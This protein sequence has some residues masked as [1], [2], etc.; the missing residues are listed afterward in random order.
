MNPII[1]NWKSLSPFLRKLR[2][3][4]ASA[5]IKTTKRRWLLARRWRE[6][7]A[8]HEESSAKICLDYDVHV[9]HHGF[10]VIGH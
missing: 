1:I 9:N 8:H 3:L 5:V 6:K 7:K 4:A 2:F 10:G